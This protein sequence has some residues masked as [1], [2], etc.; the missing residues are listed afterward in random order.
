MALQL[1]DVRDAEAFVAAIANRSQL[2]VGPDDSEDLR[3]YLL[4]ELWVLS[5]RYEPGGVNF[6]AWAIAT[7]RL[8]VIDWQ[9]QRFG[10]RRWKFSGA[11]TN[12]RESRPSVTTTSSLPIPWGQLSPRTEATLRQ[13]GSRLVEGFSPKEIANEF[14]TSSS[15]VLA[16]MAEA[17][18]ELCRLS[19]PG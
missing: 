2:G 5:T 14:G 9:R 11:P 16:R 1:Y 12:G 17:Q 15:L 3:Q 19:L 4:T 8:R 13:I 6:S 10:R 7:L 18:A